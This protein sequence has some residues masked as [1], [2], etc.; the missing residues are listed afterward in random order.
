MKP[1][2]K[3]P[4]QKETE[5]HRINIRISETPNGV[6]INFSTPVTRFEIDANSAID[7]GRALIKHGRRVHKKGMPT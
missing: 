7:L 6:A 5:A 1:D 3:K 2:Q 4:N